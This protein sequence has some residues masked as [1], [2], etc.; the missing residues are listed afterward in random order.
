MFPRQWEA[1]P[2]TH[3]DPTPLRSG[4]PCG[5]A[6]P[7]GQQTETRAAGSCVGCTLHIRY[8]RQEPCR[9]DL[10]FGSFGAQVSR[11][12]DSGAS[13]SSAACWPWDLRPSWCWFVLAL[14]VIPGS[15]PGETE[16]EAHTHA[17]TLTHTQNPSPSHAP[18]LNSYPKPASLAYSFVLPF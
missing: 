18:P 4:R 3:K 7:W 8:L 9:G 5:L 10:P 15:I 12:P 2:A 1:P 13:P 11:A 6:R 17:H 16:G 14:V